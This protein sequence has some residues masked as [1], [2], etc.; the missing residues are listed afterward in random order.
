MF[1]QFGTVLD[2]VAL[3]TLSMR[4]QAFV[5]FRDVASATNA[6]RAMQNF[7]FYDKAMVFFLVPFFDFLIVFIENPVF[8]KTIRYNCENEWYFC[9]ERKEES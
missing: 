9:R 5:C 7:P 2:V 6:M 4:G 8:E 1:S 3:K